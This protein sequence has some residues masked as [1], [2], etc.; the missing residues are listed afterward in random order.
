MFFCQYEFYGQSMIYFG[1]IPESYRAHM[2]DLG[3]AT[4]LSSIS[5]LNNIFVRATNGT[6]DTAMILSASAWNHQ[7]SSA[8]CN[9]TWTLSGSE[10]SFFLGCSKNDYGITVLSLRQLQ[11]GIHVTRNSV[12]LYSANNTEFD[13]F[14]AWL[15]I[16]ILMLYFGSWLLW[17]RSLPDD[18]DE[19]AQREQ[20]WV[21][22]CVRSAPVL[23]AVLMIVLTQNVWAEVKQSHGMYNIETIDMLTLEP[24]QV[25]LP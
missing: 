2:I 16:I 15:L 24:L 20:I 8:E 11:Y 22:T 17:T 18:I 19:D 7:V 1:D 6:H 4:L 10:A 14:T 25:F 23:T 21:N 12:H 13:E 3:N 9:T 5:D